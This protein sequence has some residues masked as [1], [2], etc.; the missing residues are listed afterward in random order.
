MGAK[1]GEGHLNWKGEW[2]PGES[3]FDEASEYSLKQ[4]MVKELHEVIEKYRG[5]VK[6]KTIAEALRKL[7]E[8]YNL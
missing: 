4:D 6:D 1:S 2:V 7:A 5:R 3:P 8:K